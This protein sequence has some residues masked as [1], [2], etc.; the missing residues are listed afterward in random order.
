VVRKK[1]REEGNLAERGE[2]VA[3][4]RSVAS[5]VYLERKMQYRMRDTR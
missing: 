2:M 1:P 5:E 4:L 3:R